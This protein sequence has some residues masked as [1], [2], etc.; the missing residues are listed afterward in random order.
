[1]SGFY[2][3]YDN[4]R[5]VEKVSPP[6][7]FPIIIANG[8]KGESYGVELT[9]DYQVTDWWRLRAGYTE[10]RIHVQPKPGS[11]DTSHGASE[12]HDPNRQFFLRSSLDLPAHL[13]FDATFRYVSLI[14]N[15]SVPAY[16]ELDL[17]LAWQPIPKL[18]FSIVGQ[19]LLHDHHAEFGAVAARQEIERGMYGKV[20]WR[21]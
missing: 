4:L 8:Q 9:A 11:T 15:L 14:A 17:R 10:L 12:S 20:L 19:N 7:P 5:S 6:A 21:F 2:N 3:D 1:M 16:S 18:E 13:Q